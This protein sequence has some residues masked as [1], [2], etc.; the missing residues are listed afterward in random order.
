MQ[1]INIVK[2]CKIIWE[3]NWCYGKHTGCEGFWLTA[4]KIFLGWGKELG[5]LDKNITPLL[6]FFP[7]PLLNSLCCIFQPP[8]I[9]TPCFTLKRLT[10]TFVYPLA[11]IRYILY[12]QKIKFWLRQFSVIFNQSHVY[13]LVIFL[14]FTLFNLIFSC[15]SL[16][17]LA[18]SFLLSYFFFSFNILTNSRALFPCQSVI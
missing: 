12:M 6:L 14:E 17:F 16:T 1:I 4:K 5:E 10:L 13:K 11:D 2:K 3:Y 9:K 15:F 18:F 7:I 8:F